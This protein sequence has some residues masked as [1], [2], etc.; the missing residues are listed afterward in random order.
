MRTYLITASRIIFISLLVIS[1]TKGAYAQYY[2]FYKP[3]YDSNRKSLSELNSL[4]SKT[5]RDTS[6]VKYLIGVA[7]HFID[8]PGVQ[9]AD[10]DSAA[11]YFKKAA[12]LANALGSEKWKHNTLM[13]YG[14]FYAEQK[15][16]DKQKE[17]YRK[18]I[19]MS[20]KS[21]NKELEAESWFYL[22]YN[23]QSTASQ[24]N[25]Y[26]KLAAIVICKALYQQSKNRP[27]EV[28]ALKELADYHLQL[29]S[30]NLAEKEMLEV[31][32]YYKSV[33]SKYIYY[34]YDL[35]S[36]VYNHKGDLSKALYYAICTLKACQKENKELEGI[37]IR[38]LAEAYAAIGKRSESI[39]WYTKSFNHYADRHE[40]I[41]L[42]I[43]SELT[44][45]L[46]YNGEAQK[47]LELINKTRKR[48]PQKD[49][50]TMFWFD[51]AFGECYTALGKF[52]QARPYINNLEKELIIEPDDYEMSTHLY[53]TIGRFYFAQKKYDQAHKNL[54][55]AVRNTTLSK[56]PLLIRLYKLLYEI[57]IIRKNPAGAIVN[58]QKYHKLQDSVFT[59]EKLNTFERLQV[60]FKASQKENEN[61]LLR[62]KSQL[63]SQQLDRDKL[64]KRT[65]FGGIG[66]LC[67]V[68]VLLYS[69]FN[70]KKR[71]NTILIKQKKTID[72]AYAKLEESLQQK[73]KLI[74]EKESL[75]KEVHHRVKNNLQL[76]MS[77]LNSQ[78]YFLED[79]SAIAAIKESQHRIKSIALVHQK[80]YQTDHVATININPYVSELVDYLKDSLGD[81]KRINFE[82]D[83]MDIE[84]DIANA[85]PLGLFLN[86][87]I[88]N[89][90]KYA[91]P[92]SLT[93]N[94]SISLHPYDQ[95]RNLLQIKDNGIGLPD[96][97]DEKGNNTLGMTLMKGLSTQ[98][99]GE[100]VIENKQGVSISLIFENKE[101]EP[102]TLND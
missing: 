99:D 11:Q 85:V 10:M 33:N 64:I 68:I 66:F 6:R 98:M 67:L 80:L 47:A 84:M 102:L 46:V 95:T 78:S 57:D 70:L 92:E 81:G 29:G 12:D 32:S 73:N 63:Q 35:I 97:F 17:V 23:L 74:S 58:L 3:F 75:I 76:T 88:T 39:E 13:A 41:C 82:L 9:K 45:E 42:M 20:Q 48:F 16:P 19:L 15:L 100:L 34:S 96:G 7:D 4:L 38:R 87:A 8:R 1:I 5:G 54:L 77:L 93:G 86:E 53:F 90:F 60:E 56:L 89:I 61:E 51:M 43:L 71:V 18:A 101:S 2:S 69:R 83:L 44:T 31:I 36:A 27:K 65:T 14:Q 59:Q 91:F 26:I 62:K 94:V 49:D 25:Y 79:Q 52:D 24:D 72:I 21:G 40:P 37:F 55:K 28:F 50:E 30:Y 22:S